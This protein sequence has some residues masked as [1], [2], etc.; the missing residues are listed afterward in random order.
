VAPILKIPGTTR[1]VLLQA[2]RPLS[3]CTRDSTSH[4][5]APRGGTGMSD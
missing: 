2:H 5:V 1:R 3:A 4:L